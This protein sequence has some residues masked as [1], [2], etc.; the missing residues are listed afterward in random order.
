MERCSIWSPGPRCPASLYRRFVQV[1]VCYESVQPED[2]W[3]ISAAPVLEERLLAELAVVFKCDGEDSLALVRDICAAEDPSSRGLP[4]L[5]LTA[6]ATAIASEAA[7]VG[8]GGQRS[9]ASCCLL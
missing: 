8:R 3:L 1:Q 2:S 9:N 5:L 6:R 4:V 7:S